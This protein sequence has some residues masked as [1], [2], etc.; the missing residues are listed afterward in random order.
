MY[1]STSK[2][3]SKIHRDPNSQKQL[4]AER[5]YFYKE[6]GVEKIKSLKGKTEQESYEE[7]KAAGSFVKDSMQERK[8][9]KRAEKEKEWKDGQAKRLK[10]APKKYFAGKEEKA[11]ADSKKRAITM[12]GRKK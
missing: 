5:T 6:Q 7:L 8:E 10:D 1:I 9:V 4:K 3:K 12:S 11:K 2:T